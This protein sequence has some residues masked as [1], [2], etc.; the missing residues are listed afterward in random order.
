MIKILASTNLNGWISIQQV[1][2][3]ARI[4]LCMCL[5]QYVIH[6]IAGVYIAMGGRQ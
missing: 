6:A 4:I 2:R 1:Q 3:V 5:F